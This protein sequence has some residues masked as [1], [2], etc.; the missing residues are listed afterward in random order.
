MNDDQ[1]EREERVLREAARRIADGPAPWTLRSQV[2][3]IPAEHPRRAGRG[4]RFG[5]FLGVLRLAGA[6]ALIAIVVATALVAAG[7]LPQKNAVPPV[8]TG[9]ATPTTSATPSVEPSVTATP[10]QAP[11]SSPVPSP[12]PAGEPQI[13]GIAFFDAQHGLLVGGSD[14]SSGALEPGGSGIVWR[15]EDGGKTWAKTALDTAALWSVAV[16]G[17][18]LAWAGAVCASDAPPTCQ[19]ALL[20]SHDG[21]KTWTAISNEAFAILDFVDAND[22]WGAGPGGPVRHTTDGGRTWSDSPAQPCPAVVRQPVGVSFVDA[23]RGWVACSGDSTGTE[24]LRKA[25]VGTTDGGRTWTVLA[26]AYVTTPDVGSIPGTGLILGISMRPNGTGLFVMLISAVDGT[27]RTADGGRTWT[28]VRIGA[29]QGDYGALAASL[30]DDQNW[31][32]LLEGSGQA[33]ELARST[34]AG[35]TWQMISS[36]PPPG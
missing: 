30:V 11:S 29:N 6:A 3:A 4:R 16:V 32:L 22:G 24:Q 10:S 1:F 8:A 5:G 36:L 33:L 7:L 35:K 27:W 21:G 34:D 20:A 15:T 14:N 28:D 12:S 13:G 17:P 25:V 31:W 23:K 2:A 19:S 26:S 18:S 9:S